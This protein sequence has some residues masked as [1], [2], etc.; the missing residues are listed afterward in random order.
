MDMF[1]NN[2]GLFH[3]GQKII[4]AVDPKTQLQCRLVCKTWKDILED[5]ILNFED[6]KSWVTRYLD[7]NFNR[8]L[9]EEQRRYVVSLFKEWYPPGH[10]EI[11]QKRLNIWTKWHDF[12]S[13]IKKTG[14]KTALV[15]LLR[16]P[17]FLNCI[18]PDT[19]LDLCLTF[20]DVEIGKFLIYHRLATV[21]EVKLRLPELVENWQSRDRTTGNKISIW[22]SRKVVQASEFGDLDT[23][24][25]LVPNP[26]E[27]FQNSIHAD[28]FRNN[29]IHIAAKLGHIDIVK[30]FISNQRNLCAQNTNRETPLYLAVRHNR[31]E[32]VD[33]IC[34]ALTAHLIMTEEYN[35]VP[36]A[37]EM[38][39]FEIVKLLLLKGANPIFPGDNGDTPIHIAA[40]NQD[41]KM[42]KLLTS[43]IFKF[44]GM[45]GLT[46]LQIAK[47]N[48][49]SEAVKF[50]QNV[51]D[52]ASDHL[53]VTDHT[54]DQKRFER[55]RKLDK[56][57]QDDDDEES[58]KL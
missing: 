25:N 1:F 7:I 45:D 43:F 51:Q 24:K 56:L 32:I 21:E 22:Y 4:T 10:W 13:T 11:Y 12:I 34:D 29:P 58:R 49:H 2:T 19:P 48:G 20:G 14:R 18:K 38:G 53:D 54:K 27:L 28:Q 15:F 26:N 31:I 9:R 50:L 37:T 47:S 30:Y 17:T 8:I 44:P 57:S 52:I 46:P 16:Q 35:V 41:L 6:L 23:L 33:M 40:R 3:I 55:K 36:L 39:H 5:P 42:L